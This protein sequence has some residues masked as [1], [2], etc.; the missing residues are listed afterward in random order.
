MNQCL[1]RLSIGGALVASLAAC[2]GGGSSESVAAGD[3]LVSTSVSGYPHAVNI[4]IPSSGATRAIVAL[5][6]GGGNN[7]AIAYQLGLNSSTSETTGNTINWDW[8]RTN[9]VI[10]VFPQGQHIDGADGAGTWSNHAMTSGQN[11][12]AFLQ[13]LA[14]KLRNE[15]GVTGIDL[16]GHS[17]GGAMT[18]RMWCESP[19]TFGSYV[20]LAG[21]AAEHFDPA[22][23][24]PCNPQANGG[25]KPYMSISGD[26]DQVMRTYN[27]R[28]S[29]YNW[30]VNPLVQWAGNAA[31]LDGTM[32]GEWPEQQV[33][34]TKMCG[35]T[36]SALASPDTTSGN[37]STWTNCGGSLVIKKIARADHGVTSMATQMDSSNPTAM[38]DAV[39]SFL[40][41]Q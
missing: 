12:V 18:N 20:A 32:M 36:V 19:G 28:W 10:M 15:Y 7:T 39:M 16:M 17:M 38:M 22:G 13:A 24:T 30:I 8:L 11:D 23:T 4:Y 9:K 41:A 31:F 5:H 14:A 35:Q 3:S 33:R 26:A 34:V 6:G 37:V 2:G 21:P 1:M 27:D 29:S 40:N 25:I